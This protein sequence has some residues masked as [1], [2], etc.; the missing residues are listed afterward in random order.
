M[1]YIPP[2][3]VA[4]LYK[5]LTGGE[6]AEKL[7]LCKPTVYKKLRQADVKIRNNVESQ[8]FAYIR[9]R[10]KG[11][12]PKP[13]NYPQSLEEKIAEAYVVGSVIGDGHVSRR[14]VRLKVTQEDFRDEFAEC[15]KRAYRF[16]PILRKERNVFTCDAC[17]VLLAK[18]IREL[19]KDLKEIPNFITNGNQKIKAD[20][21]KGF[22]DAEGS[23]DDSGNKRQ[24]IITQK[25]TKILQQ[26]QKLLLDIGIQSTIYHKTNNPDQLV[27]SLLRNLK[28]YKNLIGFNIGYK[29]KKLTNAI[30]YLK[31]CTYSTDIYW[32]CLRRWT[33]KKTSFR[34]LARTL[35]IKWGTI[36]VWVKGIKMPH[37]IRRDITYG[38]IPNDYKKLRE[39]F[40]F[41]PK[42]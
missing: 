32:S 33:N 42:I 10:L 13:I 27:V 20:F 18:R 17:R 30:K 7:G 22:A 38:F 28:R 6:I 15:V 3:V 1:K 16:N 25:N 37:Q 31:K 34:G 14:A 36:R 41:L 24:I 40:S 11:G 29:K 12:S 26:I 2:Y 23:F 8:K 19:T 5:N 4:Q 35:N 39:N 21:I 9:G